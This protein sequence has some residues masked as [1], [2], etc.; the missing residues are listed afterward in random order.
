[1]T[2]YENALWSEIVRVRTFLIVHFERALVQLEK[3]RVRR[4]KYTIGL[5]LA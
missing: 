1:M 4:R 2:F 5:N 3:A